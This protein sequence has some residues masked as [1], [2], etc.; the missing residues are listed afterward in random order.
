MNPGKYIAKDL[1]AHDGKA[2][3]IRWNIFGAVYSLLQ[4][5]SE[6]SGRGLSILMRF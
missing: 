4:S 3:T 5:V 6:E 1:V 2:Q